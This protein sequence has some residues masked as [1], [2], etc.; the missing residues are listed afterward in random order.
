MKVTLRLLIIS[1]GNKTTKADGS[2]KVTLLLLMSYGKA[3]VHPSPSRTF[4]MSS[5]LCVYF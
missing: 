4:E 5:S 1:K 3:K 2:S